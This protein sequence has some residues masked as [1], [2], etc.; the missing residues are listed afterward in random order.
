[1]PQEFHSAGLI[2]HVGLTPNA[3]A[4]ALGDARTRECR[5]CINQAFTLSVERRVPEAFVPGILQLKVKTA[6]LQ[7]LVL[8]RIEAKQLRGAVCAR[9]DLFIERNEQSHRKDLFPQVA[10]V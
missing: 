9:A 6:F 5:N 4:T 7:R 8:P 10:L 1:M 3:N 2:E